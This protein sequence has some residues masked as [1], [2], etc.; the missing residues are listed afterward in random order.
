MGSVSGNLAQLSTRTSHLR[1]F[2]AF[3]VRVEVVVY[4]VAAW[5]GR[6]LVSLSIK[7]QYP[8]YA[9]HDPGC[10]AVAFVRRVVDIEPSNLN[11]KPTQFVTLLEDARTCA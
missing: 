8:S 10:Q 6:S 3:G 7:C 1:H 4:R 9:S 11:R 2:A 5:P